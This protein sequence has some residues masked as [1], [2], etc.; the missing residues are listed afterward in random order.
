MRFA[1][2]INTGDRPRVDFDQIKVFKLLLPPISEQ[3]R[4]ADALDELLSDL[5]AAVAALERAQVKLKHYRAV[6]LKAAVEGA[7]TADWRAD[8]PNTEPASALL[9]RS[10]VERRCRWEEAQLLKFKETGKAPP[11][12]WKMKYTEPAEPDITNLPPLP[13]GS[14]WASLD[15]LAEIVGG[16]H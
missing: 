1:S 16:C 3:E 5:D 8:H 7:L 12:G 10:L 2:H 15:Q 4:I 11:K 9:S 13:K 14:C 6:V